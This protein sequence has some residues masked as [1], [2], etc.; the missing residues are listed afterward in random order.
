VADKKTLLEI[1]KLVDIYQE[2]KQGLIRT[3]AEKE[4]RGNVTW[5]Q[6]SLLDQV[7]KQLSELDVLAKEWVKSV[8]PEAYNSGLDDLNSKLKKLGIDAQS[9]PDNF[10][11]LHT[12]AINAMVMDTLDDL[13]EANRYASNSIRQVVKRA[14]DNAVIQKLAQG[15]TVRECKKAIVNELMNKSID[16]IE[17]KNGKVM[18]LDSYA[19]TVARSR[20]REATNT[21]TINQLTALERDLVKISKH[22]TT[23]PICAAYQ[24]RVFS[25]SGNDK[26]YPPL[27]E[28]F[29]GPYANIHP[30]CSHVP[31]PYIEELADDPEG[32]R[33]N[34]ALPFDIDPRSQKEVDLYN[35]MR[36]KKQR[37]REDRRQWERFSLALP[38]DIPKTFQGFMS[39][40]RANGERWDNIQ[41]SYQ[42]YNQNAKNNNKA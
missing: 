21:A 20:T 13:Q 10:A 38:N 31:E 24:G 23:C 30:N 26:R 22:N 4:A 41:K 40:K 32:D 5:F 11:V 42:D 3:I 19:A 39:M 27:S 35:G 14:V 1:Q 7:D 12:E 33:R 37:L 25:I 8:I 17:G 16:A 15:Q 28:V 2:A 36:K 9:K 34:S 29:K 18:S 6:K